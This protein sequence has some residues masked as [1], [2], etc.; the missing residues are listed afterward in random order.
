MYSTQMIGKCCETYALT[1]H[2]MTRSVGSDVLDSL[3]NNS[4]KVPS[5]IIECNIRRYF[6]PIYA[7]SL[8]FKILS[9]W[10]GLMEVLIGHL[11]FFKNGVGFVQELLKILVRFQSEMA[12]QKVRST[13]IQTI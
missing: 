11:Y 6:Y 8:R 9:G 3:I 13:R 10:S 7:A 4:K 1:Y 5:K 2:N 12:K